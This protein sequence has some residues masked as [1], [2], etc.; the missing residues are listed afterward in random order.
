MNT[1]GIIGF[2]I[3]SSL[4]SGLAFRGI[5]SWLSPPKS[6]P[7]KKTNITEDEFTE[8]LKVPDTFVMDLSKVE[9]LGDWFADFCTDMQIKNDELPIHYII[10][11][12][13]KPEQLIITNFDG[14]INNIEINDEDLSKIKPQNFFSLLSPNKLIFINEQIADSSIEKVDNFLN[15]IEGK[16]LPVSPQDFEVTELV[17]G[18]G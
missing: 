16:S 6:N 11:T 2:E 18:G 10:K 5:E 3:I 12:S 7:E 15:G 9:G 13:G 4:L 17:V 1:L 8:L 14:L